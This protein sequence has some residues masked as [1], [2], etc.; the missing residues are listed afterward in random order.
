[1]VFYGCGTWWGSAEDVVVL[2]WLG[3]VLSDEAVAQ[4][5]AWLVAVE[6][7]GLRVS[8]GRH[9]GCLTA[10]RGGYWWHGGPFFCS[11]TVVADGGTC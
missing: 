6:A 9:G 4:L 3:H 8:D 7:A 2:G 1:M 11:G 10:L 5:E